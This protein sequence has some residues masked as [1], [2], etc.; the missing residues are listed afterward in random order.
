MEF[1][2]IANYIKKLIKDFFR[3]LKWKGE[4]EFMV[5]YR[6][7]IPAP[8]N[9]NEYGF[10]IERASLNVIRNLYRIR[11][12]DFF[13][14]KDRLKLKHI[15]LVSKLKDSNKIT[16]YF[17]VGVNKYRFKDVILKIQ[18]REDEAYLYNAYIFPKYR[19]KGIFFWVISKVVEYLVPYNYKRAYGIVAMTN[20][21][22]IKHAI[23]KYEKL[24]YRFFKYLKPI[25][26]KKRNPFLQDLYDLYY[27]IRYFEKT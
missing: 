24:G 22:M 23:P 12:A 14:Y 18:L 17:W 7:V 9:L 4:I 1:S 20:P 25:K 6:D 3:S 10:R 16:G 26:A 15:C 8:Y 21:A 2:K 5:R 11:R 27:L 19:G 13:D